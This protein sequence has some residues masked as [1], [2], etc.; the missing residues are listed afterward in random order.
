MASSTL[1]YLTERAWCRLFRGEYVV[2]GGLTNNIPVFT[3]GVRRQLVFRLFDVEYPWRLL[4]N[5]KGNQIE[6]NYQYN[7]RICTF[8]YTALRYSSLLFIRLTVFLFFP[9]SCIEVLIV[10]GAVLMARFL[11][12]QAA[13]SIAWLEMRQNKNHLIRRPGYWLRA[14]FIAPLTLAGILFYRGTGLRDFL[15]TLSEL[16]RSS[17]AASAL[18]AV[19]PFTDASKVLGTAPVSYVCGAV[20]AAM[21]DFLRS[22]NILL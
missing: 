20:F 8:S 5:A 17:E 7:I 21:V 14:G 10:R 19:V 9:D 6:S 15:H 2:D 3:D 22:L 4:V 12:G 13:E 18:A 1:P 16:T 11:E